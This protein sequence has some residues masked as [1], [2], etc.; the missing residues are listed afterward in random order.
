MIRSS[1]CRLHRS[2]RVGANIIFIEKRR[3][4]PASRKKCFAFFDLS[5]GPAMFFSRRWMLCCRQRSIKSACL[6]CSRRIKASYWVSAQI[7]SRSRDFTQDSHQWHLTSSKPNPCFL[8]ERISQP[9]TF[10][11]YVDT[12]SEYATVPMLWSRVSLILAYIDLS[13]EPI[14]M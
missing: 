2:S 7:K 14:Y 11:I 13:R 10:N 3:S 5:V 9:A 1:L 8:T 12:P 6:N 4:F